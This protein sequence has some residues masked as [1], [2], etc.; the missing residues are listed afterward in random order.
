MKNVTDF[1][2]LDFIDI[3]LNNFMLLSQ[4]IILDDRIRNFCKIVEEVETVN[5][6]ALYLYDNN[7]NV[8]DDSRNNEEIFSSSNG[9]SI[10]SVD[11]MMN[12]NSDLDLGYLDNIMNDESNGNN[13]FRKYGV[14]QIDFDVAGNSDDTDQKTMTV[15]ENDSR[16]NSQ[17]SPNNDISVNIS[18]DDSNSD[19]KSPVL[20]ESPQRCK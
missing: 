20:P 13:N 4:N 9:L 18:N 3:Y 16:I 7:Q 15:P 10:A 5:T 11:D 17:I 2:Y 1:M 14:D 12:G 6:D 8:T 19:G